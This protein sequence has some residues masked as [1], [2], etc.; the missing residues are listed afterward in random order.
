MAWTISHPGAGHRSETAGRSIRWPRGLAAIGFLS[1]LVS[2]WGG[3]VPYV[4]PTFNY[5]ADGSSA[6]TWSLAHS[7]LWLVPGAVGV[8]ASLAVIARAGGG[9]LGARFSLA[10]WGLVLVACGAWFVLGPFAWP[11][12]GEG[13]TYVTRATNLSRFINLVGFNL[14]V[15]L[16]LAVFGGMVLKASTGERDVLVDSGDAD[17]GAPMY[18][19][20]PADERSGQVAT[21]GPDETTESPEIS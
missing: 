6:W 1:L 17:R 4:G 10:F 14:G 12:L 5:S 9:R 7:L 3:I 8:L 13:T 18:E 21:S 19:E 11:V 2:A 20:A 15:G 16:V